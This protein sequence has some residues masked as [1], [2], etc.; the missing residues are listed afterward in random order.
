M[1]YDM[2]MSPYLLHYAPDNASVIIR[3][4]LDSVGLPFDAVLVDR[5]RHAQTSPDYLKLN[6]HGLIPVLEGP[7]GAIF[8]TG[9]ILLW[10]NDRHGE[11]GPSV[12]NPARADFLKWLFFISN[13]VHPALRMC[14]YPEKYV[15]AQAAHQL[16]LY[17]TMSKAIQSH[18]K[19]LDLHASQ[20]PLPLALQLY[21]AALLRW[22]ALYPRDRDRSWFS[23]ADTPHLQT[24]C[25]AVEQMPCAKAA[26]AAE[27]LGPTP[28]TAPVYAAP[29]KGT[30]T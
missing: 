11:L 2:D 26:Q 10:L 30:A 15:G 17:Q 20:R 6:P 9:A 12:T 28:F 24:M 25:R 23:L 29:E 5:S 4:A 18:L 13:T 19:T 14:F 7:E 27:G 3:M 8:E 16:T 21:L 1:R 22:C